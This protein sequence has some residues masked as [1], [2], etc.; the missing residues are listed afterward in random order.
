MSLLINILGHGA[1]GFEVVPSFELA[2]FRAVVGRFVRYIVHRARTKSA[3]L[4]ILISASCLYAAA[5]REYLAC[6][7]T[8][9]LRQICPRRGD[10]PIF[11]SPSLHASSPHFF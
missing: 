2:G 8:G 4:V 5:S 6:T 1:K 7:A 11:T 9:L 10:S 3:S